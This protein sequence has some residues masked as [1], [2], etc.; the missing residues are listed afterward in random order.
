MIVKKRNIEK[1]FFDLEKI[2]NLEDYFDIAVTYF[3]AGNYDKS[4]NY[5]DLMLKIDPKSALAYFV[6]AKTA[7]TKGDEIKAKEY[8]GVACAP[9]A[10]QLKEPRKRVV[11]ND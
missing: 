3:E 7:Y 1:V 6:K 4:E 8:S 10:K 5:A 11:E 9:S 2:A